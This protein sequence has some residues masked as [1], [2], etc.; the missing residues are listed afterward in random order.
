MTKAFPLW[1][2]LAALLALGLRSAQ[3]DA[4][5]MHNDEAVNANK[6]RDLWEGPGYRYDP[7]EFHGPALAYSTLV[8]EKLTLAKDF[9]RFTEIRLRSLPVLFGVGL[10]LLL[11]MV[12]DGLGRNATL[13]AA[14][15][16]A[17]SP[18]MVYY[19]RDYIHETLFVFFI[20]LALASGW[21][22]SQTGK[23]AWIL[24]AGA[25]LGL[26]QA[27]KETFVFNI[28]AIMGALLL[29]ECFPR[30]AP[31]SALKNKLFCPAHLAAAGLV[32]LA[33]VVLLFTSF[34]SNPS[35]L[36][37]AAGTYLVWF[38]RAQG[39]SP[40][41]HGWSFYWERLLFFHRPGGPVWSEA[42]ILLLAVGGGVAA[43]ARRQASGAG[44]A[45]VRFLVFYT[46][47][48][49]AIYTVLPYKTPW[50]A[51]GFW[52]GAILL[53]GVGA[54]ALPAWLPG[55]GLKMAAGII[56]LT[57]VAQLTFQAWQSAITYAADPRN[58]W[59]YAQ[60]LPD[61]INL[62]D[63]VDAVAQASPDRAGLRIN[64]IA[65]GYD[66]WPLPWYLRRYSQAD[67]HLTNAPG[68]SKFAAGE[69]G[70]LHDFV[71]RLLGS[72][73]FSADEI[74]DLPKFVNSL[75]NHANPVSVLLWQGLSNQEQAKLTNDQ[76]SA[77][78][79]LQLK[80]ILVQALNKMVGGKSIYEPERFQGIR[81]RRE[82]ASLMGQSPTGA[83]L[84]RLNR[85]LLEDAYPSELSK[86]LLSD[87]VSQFL[88]ISGIT[89]DVDAAH[90]ANGD[91]NH[92][93]SVLVTNLNQIITGPSI[94]DSNRFQG[95]AVRLAT[96]E[97]R[98]QNPEGQDLIRLNRRLLED[99]YPTE[100]GTNNLP[101]EPYPP[102]TI[103][104]TR[105]EPDVDQDKAGLMTG[106][107]ELRPGVFLELYVQT[108]LW[109][110]YLQH[111]AK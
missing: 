75:T 59:V 4:R 31:A 37:D 64:V 89:N 5:P 106:L 2:L 68:Y 104:S 16:T 94:Y 71:L 74:K 87:P 66:F 41:V 10:V 96:D 109:S 32:W 97:L 13:A 24:L 52:H 26:M 90:P 39:A 78:N 47:I 60:T 93:E 101:V 1:L 85:L 34:F 80:D 50:S 72:T 88:M 82:T 110:A 95:I 57:C 11:F 65:P 12:A 63:K 51:L 14:F 6:I 36:L 58:P 20:F 53:A 54:A 3:L 46:A 62:V 48:L 38:H 19:S 43:F 18:V 99:A 108:N 111:R 73:A 22:Y 30:P 92:L 81:L 105:L 40:H 29:N 28:A 69:I 8:W 98:R 107:Y 77:V 67:F 91:P 35:G 61:L 55:R 23:I 79:P 17:V 42:L 100:L 56:V 70:D 15:L 21:R 49:A 102:V 27:T 25:A 76:M 45:L 9:A 83:N 103:I 7:N 84:A 44:A 86:N 33:V